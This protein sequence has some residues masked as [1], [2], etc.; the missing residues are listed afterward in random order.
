MSWNEV[1]R[2]VEIGIISSSVNLEMSQNWINI[3]DSISSELDVEA[4]QPPLQHAAHVSQR[5]FL[6]TIPVSVNTDVQQA[7]NVTPTR[8]KNTFHKTVCIYIWFVQFGYFY[9]SVVLNAA[10]WDSAVNSENKK[11]CLSCSNGLQNENK[12]HEEGNGKWFRSGLLS[13]T[14]LN[15]EIGRSSLKRSPLWY[16]VVYACFLAFCLDAGHC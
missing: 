8:K 2:R 13:W 10:L 6:Y 11:T 9:V 7:S 14:K 1:R 16:K 3:T 12:R 5:N 15:L 4:Q